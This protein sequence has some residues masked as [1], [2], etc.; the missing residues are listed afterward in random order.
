MAFFADLSKAFDFVSQNKQ[1]FDDLSQEEFL[2]SL[3]LVLF[4][5]F[6]FDLQ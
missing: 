2:K 5:F 3:S 4:C 6:F 1:N